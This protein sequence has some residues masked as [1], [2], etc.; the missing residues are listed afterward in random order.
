MHYG[1]EYYRDDFSGNTTADANPDG[2]SSVGGA[3]LQATLTSGIF[4][5]IPGVR[6]DRF[7]MKSKCD[8]LLPELERP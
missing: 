1:L 8:G 5:F 3:F 6:V 2:I 7:T 4:E